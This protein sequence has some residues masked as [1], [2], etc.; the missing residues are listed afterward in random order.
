[1]G[2]RL[3]NV[4]GRAALVEGDGVHDLE[5]ASDGRLGP[6][7]Q[8]AL[9]NTAALH[10]IALGLAGRDPE[11]R[12]GEVNLGPPVPDPMHVFAIGLNY[13]GHAAETAKAL[14][15]APLVFTKFPGCLTGPEATVELASDTTDY[16]AELVVVIG[17]TA[18][19]VPAAD[20]W[21]VVAG[22]TIGQDLS[23]REL[24]SQGE[25]PQFSLA[26]SHDG[27]GPTGP[28]VVST[29]L[30]ENRDSL[31]IACSVNGERRQSDNTRNLIFTVPVLVEYLSGMMTLRP[32]DLMFTGTPSGVGMATGTYLRSGDVV[33]TVIEGLGEMTTTMR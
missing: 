24:Q 29:D 22:L 9:A 1:M 25:R 12:L 10:E 17:A 15:P 31:D 16:E 20:A 26:K 14:P 33:R 30:V 21:D 18:R 6:S 23:D 19:D 13:R 28:L 3:G 27:F 8:A 32:G 2:F 7:A 4:D 5:A 11:H